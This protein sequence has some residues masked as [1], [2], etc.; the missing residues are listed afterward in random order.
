MA[1]VMSLAQH[2]QVFF[3]RVCLLFAT[4]NDN[5]ESCAETCCYARTL[6]VVYKPVQ[7][8]ITNRFGKMRR[9]DILA[10]FNI[11]NRSRQF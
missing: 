2:E 1:L 8:A 6:L 11:S 3:D 4:L 9:F 5:E 10:I 7:T